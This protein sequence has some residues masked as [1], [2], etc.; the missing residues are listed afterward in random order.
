MQSRYPKFRDDLIISQLGQAE[1]ISFVIKDPITRRFFRLKQPE[2]FIAKQLDGRTSLQKIQ[3]RFEEEFREPLSLPKLE[4]FIKRLQGLC[5]IESELTER[6]LSHLQRR[7]SVERSRFRRLLYLKLKAIDPHNL[8]NAIIAHIGFFF[9]R[10]FV[11]L[12]PLLTI[13]ALVITISNWGEYTAQVKSLFRPETIPTLLLVVFIVTSLHEFAHGLTC[14]HFG[15]DVHEIGFLL[16]YFLPAFYCNVSDAW[17]FKERGKRLWVSFAGVFL[18]IFIWALATIAWRVID[19][20]TWLSSVLCITMVTSGLTTVFDLNPLIKLD[21]YYLLSDYLGIPNLRRKAFAYLGSQIK[22]K[23]FSVARRGR[24]VTGREKRIYLLYGI[25]A[26]IYSFGLLLFI[27]LKTAGFVVSKFHG[28]GLITLFAIILLLFA[29]PFERWTVRIHGLLKEVKGVIRKRKN[30]VGMVV[31]VTTILVILIFGRWELKISRECRLLPS[32]R[33]SIR[34]EVAGIIREI[35][36]DEGDT[37]VAGELVAY[38]DDTEYQTEMRKTEAEIARGQAEL[39]LLKKG[40]LEEEVERLRK[41]VEKS[42]TKVTFAQKE[43]D[44]ISELY[45]KNLIAPIE[46]ER[47][48]EEL[49][50]LGKELEHAESD[51]EV[52]LI[53][54]R[55]EKIQAAQAE[56]ARL[57]TSQEYLKDQLERTAIFSPIPGV[58]STHRLK[59]RLKEHLEVGDEICQ[60]VNCRKMLLEIPVSEKDVADVKMGQTVKLKARSLPG[61]SFYGRVIS[62]APVAVNRGNHTVVVVTSEVDNPALLLKPG[63]TG[64]ARIYCGKRR[65]IHL[66]T[67]KMVRFIRVEFW[68]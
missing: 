26:S 30:I 10:W 55:P 31:G 5:L 20:A 64:N 65:I 39:E 25:S 62:I 52:L 36:V 51:L 6:E 16:I 57:R 22:A 40:P 24:E 15:G 67:R 28:T 32:S 33:A 58:V 53:G 11:F 49:N 21:G 13:V 48:Q 46:Y 18:Q 7:M 50:V 17:L 27:F 23:L 29:G 8:F 2:Y 42:K 19:P 34:A 37:V 35:Y 44:R 68:W 1:R 63:M 38:L 43:F 3:Q 41:L 14:K 61:M 66:W 60:I 54:N 45:R 59:D 9:S 4:Q 47:A 12:V 56:I